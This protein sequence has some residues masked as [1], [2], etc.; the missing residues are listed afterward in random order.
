MKLLRKGAYKS[1]FR[2]L[3]LFD[4]NPRHSESFARKQGIYSIINITRMP[5]FCRIVKA[6]A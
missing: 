3:L 6:E 1:R 2:G 4:S 5:R